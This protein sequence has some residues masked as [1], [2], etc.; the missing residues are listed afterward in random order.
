MDRGLFTSENWKQKSIWKSV[1]CRIKRCL[2]SSQ[3]VEVSFPLNVEV[4]LDVG[5]V[6]VVIRCL[7]CTNSF[8]L[9]FGLHQKRTF[10]LLFP[11]LQSFLSIGN[12]F[13]FFNLYFFLISLLFNI[14]K[15]RKS[16]KTKSYHNLEKPLSP[17]VL[18]TR[19]F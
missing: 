6:N 18:E 3:Q 11:N 14:F 4:W 1:F 12:S 2:P 7:N 16:K 8:L 15:G 9:R 10:L 13:F 19:S 17:L 5:C